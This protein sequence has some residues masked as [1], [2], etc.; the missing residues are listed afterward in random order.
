MT[1]LVD[2]ES[3]LAIDFGSLNTRALLFDVVDGQYH[4][5]A[6]ST[7]QTTAG[8][9]FHDIGEGM[10]IV[11]Q[12]LQEV[13]G[14]TLTG[15]GAGLIMPSQPDG[16]GIDR[17]F[18]TC[19][20]GKDLNLATMG[21]LSDV[22]LL[23]AQRLA[24]TT[25]GRLVESVGLNDHRKVENQ[26]DAVIQSAP[27]V[28][29]VSGGTERGATRSV[30][31]LVELLVLASRVLPKENRPRILYCGNGAISKR[32]KE[33]LERETEVVVAPNIRP[34]IDQEDLSPAEHT[35]AEI[36]ANIYRKRI[37]GLEGAVSIS[38]APL[39]P[40]A[41]AL[42][43]M[44]RFSSRFS[45][46]PKPTLGVDLGSGSTILAAAADGFSQQSVF[47]PFGTGTGLHGVIKAIPLERIT[48]WLPV[49]I[50]ADDVRDY[51]QQ[52]T[53]FPASLPLTRETLA[54][55]QALAREILRYA[56]RR[57]A[58]RWP[59]TPF[60]FERIFI[61]GAALTQLPSHLQSLLITLDGIQPVGVNI[62][63]LDPYGL[64][65]AL[66][67]IAGSNTLLPAQI[68]ESGAYANLGTVLCPVS[69]S[70]PG[71]L[72]LK[73][74]ITYEDGRDT[75]LEIK[76]GSL[77]SLPVRNGQTVHLDVDPQHG[78]VLDPCIPGL[79]RFKIT[80][81]LCGAVVDARG[82]PLQLP[83][84]PARRMEQLQRWTRALEDR[85]TA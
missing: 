35:L 66:G 21:L 33:A 56:A 17:L 12:H 31:K 57:S 40:S 19:S 1:S 72:I 37:G 22:S 85:R 11:L 15:I 54:I 71:T 59:G 14:R 51:L 75:R 13:T 79:R 8:A 27:D 20:A 65:Q 26:L 67:A 77:V 38:S 73:M 5:I 49:E 32:V 34:S 47:R 78:A 28:V 81:G 23:S 3:V 2:A 70:K 69:D 43:R 30:N 7:A 42:S 48:R 74:K 36:T 39:L 6:S 53:L 16:S 45:D 82:R 44:M 18:L 83:E 55:E 50:P 76:Q 24:G 29:I 10:H 84:D 61:S 58:E 80:G 60:S 52:K 4:F 68:I 9:P 46:L 25:Y 41:Y 64:S 62:F 63:M